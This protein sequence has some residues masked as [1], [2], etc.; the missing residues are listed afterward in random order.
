MAAIPKNIAFFRKQ[1]K[2]SQEQLAEK[3]HVTRQTVSS[4][5]TGRTAPDLETLERIAEILGVDMMDL[6][7]GERP[8][9]DARWA[10]VECFMKRAAVFYAAVFI[11]AMGGFAYTKV[12]SSLLLKAAIGLAKE[13]PQVY[14]DM[15]DRQGFLSQLSDSLARFSMRS[16][17]G[18]L[19][20]CLV[21]IW[22]CG[23][24]IRQREVLIFL[25]VM[26]AGAAL[27]ILPFWLQS[28]WEPINYYLEWFFCAINCLLLLGISGAA[29][30]I[31]RIRNQKKTP[32]S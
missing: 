23:L 5:E 19:F 13:Q 15:L 10:R 1:K 8:P 26:F 17:P 18:L 29:T 28:G 20:L 22:I 21:L 30:F 32:G 12:Q 11:F 9:R 25:V 4:W 24:R 2:L 6:L 7:Y 3:I 16:A 27:A 14:R 31:R